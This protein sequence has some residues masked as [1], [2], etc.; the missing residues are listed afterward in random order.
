MSGRDISQLLFAAARLGADRPA[1]VLGERTVS[2]GAFAHDVADM[3]RRLVRLGVEPCDHVGLAGGNTYE[4]LVSYLAIARAGGVSVLLSS[5]WTPPELSHALV[6]TDTRHLVYE[7]TIRGKDFSD[8]IDRAA[9]ERDAIVGQPGMSLWR[10]GDDAAGGDLHTP[11]EGAK[12]QTVLDR[13]IERRAAAVT[14]E[15]LG[16][17][18]FTSGSTGFPKAAML[19]H[20]GLRQ[21]AIDYSAR[22]EMSADDRWC[23]AMP[24]FH[25]GGHLWGLLGSLARGACLVALEQFDPERCLWEIQARR[26]TIHFA[27]ATMMHDELRVSDFE[28][29]DLGSLRICSAGADPALR[30]EVRARYRVPTILSMYGMTETHGNLTLTGPEDPEWV[31]DTTFGRGYRSTEIVTADPATGEF[32]PT[33]AAGEIL[34]RGDCV[35]AGYYGDTDAT[36][37]VIDGDG[38]L[39]TGDLGSMGADGYLRFDGRLGEKIRV[40]GENVSLEEIERVV[41]RHGKVEQ[42]YAVGVPDSRL[43]EVPVVFVRPGVGEELGEEELVAHCA[44]YLATFKRPREIFIVSEFPAGASGRASKAQLRELAIAS[45]RAGEAT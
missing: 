28:R 43:E 36:R 35:F 1:L 4:W 18:V 12:E 34:V 13:E 32:L 39:H 11:V 21:N 42:V 16:S 15:S 22:L 10:L 45:M 27:V 25:I 38:W 14:E 20:S 29:F 31:Q 7:P 40:G 30:R 8:T 19:R 17:M 3:A 37:S 44:E 23:S 24:F 6:A 41:G 5:R 9:R 33:G 26:C 2:Y